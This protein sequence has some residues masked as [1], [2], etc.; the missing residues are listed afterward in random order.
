MRLPKADA[1]LVDFGI[2]RVFANQQKVGLAT[3]APSDSATV[4]LDVILSLTAVQGVQ[5]ASDDKGF[6][7]QAV[8]VTQG[9]VL[10]NTCT[11]IQ[12]HVC[13]HEQRGQMQYG[14]PVRY[15]RQSKQS[16]VARATGVQSH[17]SVCGQAVHVAQAD[18]P[19]L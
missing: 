10:S 14:D 16:C 15:S 7:L 12:C 6:T 2:A 8:G 5:S 19:S 13:V 1:C 18:S 17:I 4:P 11:Y 9:L 3:D